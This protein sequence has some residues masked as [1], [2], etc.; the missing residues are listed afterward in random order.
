MST[1]LQTK[2]S[3]AH[4]A[5]AQS[6]TKVAKLNVMSMHSIVRLTLTV[7]LR[8]GDTSTTLANDS[9]LLRRPVTGQTPTL[10]V[11]FAT[12]SS[13]KINF[14]TTLPSLAMRVTTG[15]YPPLAA[16]GPIIFSLC[17]SAHPKSVLTSCQFRSPARAPTTVPP[18]VTYN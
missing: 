11:I 15:S 3:W 18:L 17:K 6:M 14:L 5:P 2:A 16:S 10:Y 4:S 1:I 9:Q 13:T 7:T 8:N 12:T